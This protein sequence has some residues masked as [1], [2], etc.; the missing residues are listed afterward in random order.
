MIK[1][2]IRSSIK[3]LL[4]GLDKTNK[5]HPRVIDSAIEKVLAEM[6]NDVFKSDPLALQRYTK[7][8]TIAPNILLEAASG[9]YYVALPA[10][11]IPFPDKASGVRRVSTLVQGGMTFFPMD[12]R[13]VDLVRSGSYSH[14]VTAIGSKI[15]YVVTQ[16]RIEFYNITAGDA[17]ITTGVRADL[18]V[19]FSVYADTDTVLI[20][21]VTDQQGNT[22]VDRVL[23]ILGVIRPV[24]LKDDNA[25]QQ[26]QQQQNSGQ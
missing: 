10:A 25:E 14:T 15:G 7:P 21:E 22:F 11:I 4:P 12:I 26:V 8:Y 3:N 5:Y 13:E 6:Y 23:K 2:E 16:T 18:I 19:P 20:P 9:I 1:E 17:V 24:D